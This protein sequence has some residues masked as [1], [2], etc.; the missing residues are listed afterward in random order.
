ML[1]GEPATTRA[2]LNT[3]ATAVLITPAIAV[4][5]TRALTTSAHMA[6]PTPPTAAATLRG[7][8]TSVGTRR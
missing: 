5:I 2:V 4:R 3:R 1:V 8:W 7:K 6:S